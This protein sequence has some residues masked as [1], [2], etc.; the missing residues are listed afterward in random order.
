MLVCDKCGCK[1]NKEY[2]RCDAY[3][4]TTPEECKRTA[5][6]FCD[7]CY[8]QFLEFVRKAHSY[9]MTCDG[10][11]NDLFDGVVYWQGAE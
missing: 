8:D 3:I 2:C 11:A 1:L 9:F 5:V 4:H 6:D 10:N 7:D